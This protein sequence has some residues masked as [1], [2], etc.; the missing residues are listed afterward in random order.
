MKKSI[1]TLSSDF[2]L[3]NKDGKVIKSYYNPG[4]P[5]IDPEN[6]F[7]SPNKSVN[8]LK[9]VAKIGIDTYGILVGE[10][11]TSLHIIFHSF[12]DQIMHGSKIGQLIYEDTDKIFDVFDNSCYFSIARTFKNMSGMPII[13]ES[14]GLC[15]VNKF[16]IGKGNFIFRL[17]TGGICLQSEEILQVKLDWDTNL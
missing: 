12:P 3:F 7:L 10:N 8:I 5:T 13:V 17:L 15:S 11:D 4:M 16:R 1:I 9:L 14:V 6:I 2:R